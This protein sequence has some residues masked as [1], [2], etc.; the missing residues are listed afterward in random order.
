M[1]GTIAGVSSDKNIGLVRRPGGRSS[2]GQG[3]VLITSVWQADAGWSAWLRKRPANVCV[4]DIA[5][6]DF[7]QEPCLLRLL[8][9][10]T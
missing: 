8:V 10:A 4:E 3:R 2:A 5:K 7:A 9:A 6:L 1:I